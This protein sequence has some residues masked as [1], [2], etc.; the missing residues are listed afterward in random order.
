MAAHR[1]LLPGK[2]RTLD[3]EVTAF[4]SSKGEGLDDS[5][6]A[7]QIAELM[8]MDGRYEDALGQIN[9]EVFT[10]LWAR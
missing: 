7:A 1:Y 3:R 8:A 6:M 9:F 2:R 4:P 5:N 10:P